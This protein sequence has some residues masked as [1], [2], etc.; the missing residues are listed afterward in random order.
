MK[1]LATQE[2]K[3]LRFTVHI[4]DD[5][6]ERVRNLVYWE[7]LTLSDYITGLL[8]DDLKRR[9]K[10]YKTRQTALKRGRRAQ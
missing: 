10:T 8:E 5:L 3:K 2:N 9:G 1:T 6:V 4:P 7:R